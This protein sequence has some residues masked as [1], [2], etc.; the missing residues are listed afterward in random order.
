M[1]KTTQRHVC[2][3]FAFLFCSSVI[4]TSIWWHNPNILLICIIYTPSP[5]NRGLG[6]FDDFNKSSALLPDIAVLL[7]QMWQICVASATN[8][9]TINSGYLQS[10]EL[11]T[12]FPPSMVLLFIVSETSRQIFDASEKAAWSH[13]SLNHKKR[14][15]NLSPKP[16]CHRSW[17]SPTIPPNMNSF[18]ASQFGLHD[19]RPSPNTR[20]E[21]SRSQFPPS[22]SL[23]GV[24]VAMQ[25]IIWC[26]K[27]AKNQGGG[28]NPAECLAKISL[29]ILFFIRFP[30]N[31][32]QSNVHQFGSHALRPSPNTRSKYWTSKRTGNWRTESGTHFLRDP[33][34]NLIYLLGTACKIYFFNIARKTPSFFGRCSFCYEIFI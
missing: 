15:S 34:C 24:I 16:N 8:M 3:K 30:S 21:Y 14:V 29:A 13:A 5:N 32:R 27:S 28:G 10:F 26:V 22:P 12:S 19:L 1:S 7:K 20:W 23:I 2:W 25:N 9:L 4:T 31:Y 17:I 11:K 18:E 6:H 33:V